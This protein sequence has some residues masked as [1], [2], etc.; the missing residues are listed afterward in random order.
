[1]LLIHIIDFIVKNSYEIFLLQELTIFIIDTKNY[2]PS[3]LFI[4]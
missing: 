2:L 1:M 4:L 3:G